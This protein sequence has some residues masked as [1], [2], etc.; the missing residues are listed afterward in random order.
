[1]NG[2]ASMM[3]TA[4]IV[5]GP[6][7]RDGQQPVDVTGLWL[8]SRGVAAVWEAGSTC[9]PTG[10]CVPASGCWW[11]AKLQCAHCEKESH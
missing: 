6:N 7:V 10:R 2:I 11:I 3:L 4:S 1:M 9:V 8:G 5:V